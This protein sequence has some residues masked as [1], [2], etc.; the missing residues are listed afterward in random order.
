MLLTA[1]CAGS[2]EAEPSQVLLSLADEETFDRCPPITVDR[3]ARADIAFSGV[4]DIQGGDGTE[5]VF[6]VDHWFTGGDEQR[7]VVHGGG[8][9]IGYFADTVGSAEEGERYLVAGPGLRRRK[10]FSTDPEGA[11]SACLT[12]LWSTQLADRFAAAFPTRSPRPFATDPPRR[13]D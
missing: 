6:T 12:R 13:S 4:L 1:S 7:V 8:A 5:W 2:P 3:L 9:S 10:E 11:A